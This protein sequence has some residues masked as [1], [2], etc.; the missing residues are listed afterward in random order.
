[1]AAGEQSCL[2]GATISVGMAALQWDWD[3]EHLL[4]EVR[5]GRL[6][7]QMADQSNAGE[8]R[9]ASEANPA[10]AAAAIEER[11]CHLRGVSDDIALLTAEWHSHLT[12]MTLASPLT[13]ARP[14]DLSWIVAWC[15]VADPCPMT[16][17]KE[18]LVWWCSH[19]SDDPL[20]VALKWEALD[21]WY[22]MLSAAGVVHK[23]PARGTGVMVCET[24]RVSNGLGG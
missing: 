16:A 5:C 18:Q 23:R 8:W 6:P 9:I 15:A 2:G 1:M 4:K 13:A 21:A 10:D 12:D 22:R 19:E 11:Y 17:T 24:S 3:G 7:P 20:A 14:P